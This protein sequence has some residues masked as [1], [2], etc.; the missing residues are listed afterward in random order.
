MIDRRPKRIPDF[1]HII[2]RCKRAAG[3]RLVGMDAVRAKMEISKKLATE[4]CVQSSS[5]LDECLDFLGLPNKKFHQDLTVYMNE[6]R[7]SF[8]SF[9]AALGGAG[10]LELL[11][12]IVCGFAGRSS[13]SNVKA[14]ETGVSFGFSSLAMLGAVEGS[15]QAIE[16]TSIDLGIYNS[17]NYLGCAVND[18]LLINGNVSWNLLKGSDRKHISI[19]A[20]QSKV[21]DIIHYDSDKSFEGKFWALPL[22][23]KMLEPGGILV[24]DDIGDNLAFFAFCD[25]YGLIPIIVRSKVSQFQGVCKKLNV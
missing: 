1:S 3:N 12:N 4:K 7:R 18:N 5:S 6:A 16:L 25:A 10:N 14:L 11:Y 20:K 15:Q 8:N 23:Y 9:D 24:C 21:F 2:Y 22:L 19:L 13:G 17:S